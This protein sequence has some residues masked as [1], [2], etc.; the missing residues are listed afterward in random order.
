MI[1]Y[2]FG[3]GL[4]Y[5]SVCD[6]IGAVHLAWQQFGWTCVGVSEIAPFPSAVVEH[7]FGFRNLGDMKRFHE[8]P[9]RLLI[10]VDVLVGGTPCQSF[11][12]LGNRRGL[13]DPRG[14]LLLVFADLYRHI[15]LVRRKH[16]RPPAIALFENVPRLR[17]SKD[18][19]FGHFV[20]R[21]LGCDEAPET[22]SGKWPYSGF[23]RSET[24]RVGWRILNSEFFRLAQRRRRLFLV[25][26]PCELVERFGERACPSQI[27]SLPESVRGG[28][29]T[30]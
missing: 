1:Q 20:G 17:A 13:D 3:T 23:L 6:G 7:H 25:A 14:I 4:R 29:P 30:R 12:G 2:E 26:V 9:E 11:S 8:W 5:L 18:N 15:N 27:L 10:D 21:L 16:G 24:I 28:A 19:A 22:E